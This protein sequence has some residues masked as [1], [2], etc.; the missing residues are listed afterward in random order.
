MKVLLEHVLLTYPLCIYHWQVYLYLN[1]NLSCNIKYHLFEVSIFLVE[2]MTCDRSIKFNLKDK[3]VLKVARVNSNHPSDTW[4]DQAL[5]TLH[6]SFEIFEIRY[7][8]F[9][10]NCIINNKHKHV[11]I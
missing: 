9:K 10:L 3:F 6:C 5:H 8:K 7:L 2:R 11:K 4:F 1:D